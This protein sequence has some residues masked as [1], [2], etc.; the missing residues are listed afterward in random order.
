MCTERWEIWENGGRAVEGQR[1]TCSL[2]CYTEWAIIWQSRRKKAFCGAIMSWSIITI[3]DPL[4][5]D[6][7]AWAHDGHHG[8]CVLCCH[9]KMNQGGIGVWRFDGNEDG[10]F[11]S[12]EHR[13][14]PLKYTAHVGAFPWYV[15]R[16]RA[17]Q[18]VK[19]NHQRREWPLFSSATYV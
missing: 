13:N 3:N 5:V 17:N 10:R 6:L 9:S 14:F 12:S 4:P 16:M 19:N 7:L 8:I 2:I 1:P 18:H 11:P 15:P